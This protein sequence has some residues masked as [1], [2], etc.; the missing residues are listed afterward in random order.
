MRKFYFKQLL[1]ALLLLCSAMVGATTYE[2]WTSTN[3]SN[4]SS[5]YKSYRIEANRGDTLKFNWEVSSEVDSDILTVNIADHTILS[6]SGEDNGTYTYIFNSYGTYT[7]YVEYT[8]DGSMSSGGDYGRIYNI[9]KADYAISKFCGDNITWEYTDGTLTISGSGSMYNYESSSYTLPWDKYK[10]SIKN[11]IIKEGVTNIGNNALSNCIKLTSITLPSS[12]T[13]IGD[14]AF[15]GCSKLTN[16]T[17]PYGLKTIGICAFAFCSLKNIDIP[18]SLIS[19]GDLAFDSCLFTSIDI[20]NSVTTIGHGAF[21]YNS[22]ESINLPN[23][24][25]T[26]EDQTF[27]CCTHLKNITIPESVTS[28]GKQAF[29]NCYGLKS[30]VIPNSVTSIGEH[31]F[32]GCDRLESVTSLIP[33]DKLFGIHS[34]VFNNVDKNACT[35][36]VPAG[37]KETYAA[38]EGWSE[39]TNIV[40]ITTEKFDFTISAA[41]YSTLYLD[42]NAII[43]AGLRVYYAE[44]IEGETLM[45]E[46]INDVIPANTAVIVTGAAGT[47]IFE[48][49]FE[50]I[51][52][53][54]NNLFRGSVEDTYITPEKGTKY[55]VLSIVD[56]VVGM[57]LDELAGGTFKNNAH[58]AYLPLDGESLGIFD[59]TV[60]SPSAQLSNRYTFNFGGTTAVE[61]VNAEK[62]NEVIYDLNGQRVENPTKGIYIVNG[63]KVVY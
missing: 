52:A 12:L 37:A 31:T 17:L 19:I 26:I 47:Y 2:D 49:T 39:F 42:Y 9:E 60:N 36:Y 28:I 46:R 10:E 34:S 29:Y 55:Y 51:A 50:K 62:A 15:T 30:V 57:Y 5:S 33:A 11:V 4:D 22:I 38:T 7:L 13:H 14:Y 1:T 54:E 25:K 8:K 6:K 18:N 41:K 45:M 56:G 16:I 40:E 27:F 21:E 61:V 20:P 24:I 53:I 32:Y 44:K 58:K 59:T 63:K 48:Q 3:K 35:L 23:N 43:P